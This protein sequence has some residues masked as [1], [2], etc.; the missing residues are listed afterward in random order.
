MNTIVKTLGALVIAGTVAAGGSAFTA[1]GL[2][3]DADP[4]Q[5]I[6]GTV[7]QT[8]DGATL[9]AVAYALATPVETQHGQQR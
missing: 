2:T 8:V 9:D 5:F 7:A 3:N 1:G 6:G 4:S